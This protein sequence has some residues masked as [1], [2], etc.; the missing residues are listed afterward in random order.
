MGKMATKQNPSIGIR[1]VSALLMS[2]AAL[3][4]ITGIP[5]WFHL[6]RQDLIAAP[7]IIAF[8]LLFALV[9]AAILWVG[10]ALWS[11]SPRALRVAKIIFIAQIPS[12][13]VPGFVYVFQTLG[14]SLRLL[15]YDG[16]HLNMKLGSIIS[17]YISPLIHELAFGVNIVALAATI[18]LLR[19]ARSPVRRVAHPS[20][21]QQ[22]L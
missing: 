15:F 10:V 14:L 8:D 20:P 7:I 21:S 2:G 22:D 9:F 4:I 1:V 13:S 16:P 18:Y 6:L 12:V 11:G 19:S 17:I 3:G 5:L